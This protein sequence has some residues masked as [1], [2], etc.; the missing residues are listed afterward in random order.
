V[1]SA[2]LLSNSA[3]L[4]ASVVEWRRFCMAAGSLEQNQRQRLDEI[5]KANAGTVFSRSLRLEGVT[6]WEDFASHVP[7]SRYEDYMPW[8]ETIRQ[9]EQNILTALPVHCL[10]PTSGSS[11]ARKLVPYTHALRTEL[12][13][14]VAAWIAPLF[15]DHPRLMAGRAYWS[16]TPKVSVKDAADGVVPVGFEQDCEYLGGTFSGLASH[17]LATPNEVRLLEDMEDFWHATLLFLL[18]CSDLRLISAWHPSFISLLLRYLCDHWES[19]LSDLHSGWRSDQARV[20]ISP[21]R[22]RAHQLAALTPTEAQ[23]IWPHLGLVS[24]WGGVGTRPYLDAIRSAFPEALL[25]PKGLIATEAVVTIPVGR[26]MPLA[27]RSHF[28]E[29][30]DDDGRVYA[31]WQLEEGREYTVIVTTGGGL[32]RYALGDRVRVD[33]YF[34]Q[35]PSLEF[36]DRVGNVSDLF[37]EKLTEPFVAQVLEEAMQILNL[38]PDFLMIAFEPDEKPHYGLYIESR[39]AIPSGLA[40]HIDEGL[41]ENPHYDLCRRIGQLHQVRIVSL[42]PNA[43]ARY[44]ERLISGGIRLGDIKPA[45]LSTLDRWCEHL[46]V[47]SGASEL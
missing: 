3:W 9:G 39:Q 35:T 45:V 16:L 41:R 4:A 43:F 46:P 19:L 20:E 23:R 33:G 29:F 6:C 2:A 32:C 25:Q 36:I 34:R 40:A 14:A 15:L 21:A 31:S 24:C 18:R 38:S 10:E 1:S 28:F 37:G 27:L 26:L 30:Q 17:I 22:A 12:R 42:K 44:S 47:V 11:G 8:I 13:R 5:L 7:V